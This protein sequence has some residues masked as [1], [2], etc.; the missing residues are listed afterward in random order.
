MEKKILIGSIISIAMLI[1]ICF[2][3]VVGYQS[4]KSD[5][6]VSPLFNIRTSRAI[7]VDSKDLNSEYVGKGTESNLSIPSI[8]TRISLLLKAQEQI[9]N[10]NKEEID[11]LFFKA[12]SLLRYEEIN[13]IPLINDP[14]IENNKRVGNNLTFMSLYTICNWVPGCILFKVATIPIFILF[15]I[16]VVIFMYFFIKYFTV[17]YYECLTSIYPC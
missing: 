3:S 4:V 11:Q 7:D 12:K 14:I 1:G 17:D 8:T 6:K 13:K 10:M 15:M 9:K 2:T 16:F 5:V